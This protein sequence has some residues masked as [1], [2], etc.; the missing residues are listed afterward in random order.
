M[1]TFSAWLA[2]C[3]GISPVTGEFH[4]QGPVTRSFDGFF[5]LRVNK[6]LSKQWWGWLL[7][8]LSRPLWR[9]CND[10]KQ[11]AYIWHLHCCPLTGICSHASFVSKYF[12]IECKLIALPV[13]T[14]SETSLM[15]L[16]NQST[17][18]TK[19]KIV[20]FMMITRLILRDRNILLLI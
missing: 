4:A 2:I 5:D 18:Q 20:I 7:E 10:M 1:E 9:H 15:V 16:Y 17:P 11:F 19:C 3:V 12:I 13:L 8:T 6:P 14:A